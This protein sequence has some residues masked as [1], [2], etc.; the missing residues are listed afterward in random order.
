VTGELP[1]SIC[2]CGLSYRIE[3]PEVICRSDETCQGRWVRDELL[4]QVKSGQVPAKALETLLHEVMHAVADRFGLD[5]PE[6]VA[7]VM[8]TVIQQLC[9]ENP[10]LMELLCQP[11]NQNPFSCV[12]ETS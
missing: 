11:K 10:K 9:A 8:A 12:T 6:N 2:I 4:I 7:T 3:R 1:E 5:I